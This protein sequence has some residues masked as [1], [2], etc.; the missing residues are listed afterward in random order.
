MI[1]TSS[2]ITI[3]KTLRHG[4]PT[5]YTINNISLFISHSGEQRRFNATSVVNATATSSGLITFSCIDLWEDGSYSVQI[6]GEN[7]NDI[8]V[9][10]TG[11]T[12]LGTGFIKKITDTNLLAL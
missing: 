2:I 5:S 9:K 1:T 11:L 8:D 12:K 3:T 6:T 10:G 7:S 4:V